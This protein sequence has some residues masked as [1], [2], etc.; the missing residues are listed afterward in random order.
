M[1]KAECADTGGPRVC[2]RF[3]SD[4]KPVNGVKW[5]RGGR[6]TFK[7]VFEKIPLSNES[8][9]GKGSRVATERSVHEFVTV[10]GGRS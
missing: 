6:N 4:R 10:Q 9:D 7:F 3:K 5:G 8:M 2:F 1:S